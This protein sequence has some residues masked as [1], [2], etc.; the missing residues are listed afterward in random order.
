MNL[1]VISLGKF[2]W[3]SVVVW[4]YEKLLFDDK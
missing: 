3:P 1:A 2:L 4:V